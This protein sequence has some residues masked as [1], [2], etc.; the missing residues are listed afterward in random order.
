MSAGEVSLFSRRAT[1]AVGGA[2]V[3]SLLAAFYLLLFPGEGQ[4]VRGVGPH[5]YS[6]S[7]IGHLGLIQLLRDLGEPVLQ[8]RR[9]R[10]LDEADRKSVV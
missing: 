8:L 1:L 6:R 7:A 3:L 4:G 2:A 5:G 10:D 9:T